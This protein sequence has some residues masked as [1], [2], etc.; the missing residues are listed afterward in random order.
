M[1]N[2]AAKMVRVMS[3]QGT[4][5]VLLTQV[6]CLTRRPNRAALFAG[7]ATKW[8]DWMGAE[9][10]RDGP[11][12]QHIVQIGDPV[13]R[14]PAELVPKE[15]IQS[16]NIKDVLREM[17][18]VLERYSS[19][20]LAAPQIGVPLQIFIMQITRSQLNGW[21]EEVRKERNAEVVPLQIFINP[22]VKVLD[23]SKL[24][25]REG[26][27]SMHGFSGRIARAKKLQLNAL[28]ENGETVE[29]KAQDWTAR[30]IQHEVDHLQG[31]VIT[32]RM[33]L[34]SLSMDYWTYVN[35]RNGKFK[36]SY[37][38]IK[39][40]PKKWLHSPRLWKRFM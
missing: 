5:S 23:N 27:C 40:G 21:K 36:L 15:D 39:P 9:S 2:N 11:P 34:S 10:G 8:R 29:I 12:Y 18:F 7:L 3:N 32:D 22:T 31:L 35:R 20:G 30:I 6:R 1:L 24:I 13:L 38:G 33:D 4:Q 17:K 37:E 25:L 28:N 14:Q 26:C 16:E 19:V